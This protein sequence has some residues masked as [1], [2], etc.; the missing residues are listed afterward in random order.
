[1]DPQVKI[2]QFLKTER[3]K[4]GFSQKKLAEAAECSPS[5][6]CMFEKGKTDALSSERLNKICEVLR[7]DEGKLI[8]STAKRF[9]PNEFCPSHSLYELGDKRQVL[10]PKAVEETSGPH[11]I[12]CGTTYI[13]T[14]DYCGAPFSG[15]GAF[16]PECGSAY[17]PISEGRIILPSAHEKFKIIQ[18]KQND[19]PSIAERGAS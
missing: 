11:C 14:C 10:S 18:F 15:N 8:A 3:Q 19:A 9:C 12:W 17:I 5:A 4:Q 16:C 1:M 6:L 13:S 7:L 2:G